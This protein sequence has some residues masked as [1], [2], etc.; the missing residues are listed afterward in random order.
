MF[1]Q[2][3]GVMKMQKRWRRMWDAPDAAAPPRPGIDPDKALWNLAN[4]A[5]AGGSATGDSLVVA[6]EVVAGVDRHRSYP[7]AMD[8]L[9]RF[10]ERG[11]LLTTN[12]QA[13]DRWLAWPAV[14]EL[15][16]GAC[17][18]AR[19]RMVQGWVNVQCAE[20]GHGRSHDLAR[21]MEIAPLT[22]MDTARHWREVYEAT[23]PNDPD[24]QEKAEWCDRLFVAL[25][26]AGV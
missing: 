13:L 23:D 1:K 4:L 26:E 9:H 5:N 21:C 7:M 2:T 25:H 19:P 8:D 3:R 18:L 16:E 15:A 12:G 17:L 24:Y 22:T 20:A 14:V 6:I 10:Y 11:D